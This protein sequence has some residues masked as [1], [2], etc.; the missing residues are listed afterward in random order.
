MK[1]SELLEGVPLL[2]GSAEAGKTEISALSMHSEACSEGSLFFA[3]RGGKEDG[4]NYVSDAAARGAVAV[5]TERPLRSGLKEIL[6][7]D[8]RAALALIAGNF[9]YNA[10]RELKIITVTGTNGKTTTCRMISEIL[11]AANRNVAVFG[12]LGVTINGREIPSELTTPDPIEL[13][14]LFQIAHLAGVEY[15]VM[16]ASAHAIALRKL[17]GIRAKVAVFTNLTQDHLD[18]FG[19]MESYG[20]CKASYFTTFAIDADC[21]SG[22]RCVVNSF[23]DIF[24]LVTPFSGEFNLYNALAAVTVTRLLSVNTDTIVRA[25][26]RMPEVA[27][28]FN[29][30]ESSKRVIIDFAHTPDGLKNLLTAARAITRGRLIVVFGCGGDRDPKKRSVMG[31]IAAEYADFGVLTSDNSRTEDPR[32]I[33]RQIENGYKEISSSYITIVER[34]SAITYAVVV[35]RPEDVVV[36]AGKGAEPYMDEGGVKRPYSDRAEVLEIFRRYNL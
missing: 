34:S 4:G 8:A 9:Y 19:D 29:I 6:V 31:R 13:H 16:E 7:P 23:D 15:V 30:I 26:F 24:E 1:L 12:T 10:H 3:I 22:T 33:I 18:F 21:T 27:G 20:K 28:R 5:V 2:E 25:F 14:R 17:T 35:A 32:D 11:R 36:I